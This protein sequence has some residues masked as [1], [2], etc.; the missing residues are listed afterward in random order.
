MLLGLEVAHV[1]FDDIV[2]LGL[3]QHDMATCE[4]DF[5]G[6]LDCSGQEVLKIPAPFAGCRHGAALRLDQAAIADGANLASLALRLPGLAVNTAFT[7]AC[8]VASTLRT[9]L[10]V[11]GC[12]CVGVCADVAF[13]HGVAA[14]C[15][16]AAH[17]AKALTGHQFFAVAI[18][19]NG[20]F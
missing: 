1:A 17:P 13:G 3:L 19:V 5:S 16:Q 10:L 14:A 20:F 18:S 11:A 9:A 4:A 2:G 7:A 6:L 8:V 12:A 15:P